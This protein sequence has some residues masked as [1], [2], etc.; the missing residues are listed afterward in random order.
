M[1]TFIDHVT[2]TVPEAGSFLAVLREALG[3]RMEENPVSEGSQ[4]LGNISFV[5]GAL[6]IRSSF[7]KP[8]STST[9]VVDNSGPEGQIGRISDFAIRSSDMHNDVDS[10]RQGG[11]TLTDPESISGDGAQT[12]ISRPTTSAQSP[13]PRLIERVEVGDPGQDGSLR[14]PFALRSIEEVTLIVT[15]VDAVAALYETNYRT[16]V[17]RRLGD[18]LQLSLPACKITLVAKAAAPVEAE[19]GIFSVSLGTTDIN[20]ARSDLRIRGIEFEDAPFSLG[21]A[22]QIDRSRMQGVRINFVQL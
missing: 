9:A 11:A 12:R 5:Q 16:T 21:V 4:V 3:F 6:R 18:I 8:N 2:I 17:S 13:M 22:S 20:G 10:L 15:N 1:L 19:V 7:E 14:Q